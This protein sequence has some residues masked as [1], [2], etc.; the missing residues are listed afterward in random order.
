MEKDPRMEELA[1]LMSENKRHSVI[2]TLKHSTQ[3]K[4][5]G[6][7]DTQQKQQNQWA[8]KT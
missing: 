7:P 5:P 3:Q 8:V 6:G 2:I 1:S 4:P